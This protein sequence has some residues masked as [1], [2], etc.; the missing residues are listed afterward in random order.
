M[1]WGV[2][3][4]LLFT[5][6][7]LSAALASTTAVSP[8][9]SGPSPS[10]TV[11]QFGGPSG[12][13][14]PDTLP[15]QGSLPTVPG[16]T[17][18]G[19]AQGST[20]A[21]AGIDAAAIAAGV[22]PG[23]VDIN[24]TLVGGDGAAGTGMVL[25]PSGLVLTNNHVIENAS[26]I[27]AQVD[28]TG[29]SYHATVVGYSVTDDVAL[30]QLQG[31]TG[32]ATVTT[33]NADSLSVGQSIVAIGNALGQGGTPSAV[34][35][36]V[37]ALDQSIT[38]GD[39]GEASETLHGLVQIDAPIQP[40]DSGGPVVDTSGQVVGMTTAAS[41]GQSQGFGVQSGAGQGYAITIDNALGLVR[42]IEAG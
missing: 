17:T 11:P 21:S 36:A 7:A 35:G 19:S 27:E 4:L 31:A 33:G 32:L 38:A 40:G 15:S 26:T 34:A 6:A 3:A 2:A 37:T 12:G 42:Q 18:P 22:D 9:A 24:T 20:G 5:V 8:A 29:P 41:V 25:T 23:L 28:G 10:G 14:T 13:T 39:P 16:T 30:V 1:A